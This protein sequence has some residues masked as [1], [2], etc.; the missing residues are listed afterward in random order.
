MVL[1][2]TVLFVVIPISA[3]L[4][5]KTVETT[6]PIPEA[7]G[8]V[9]EV[10]KVPGQ[11]CAVG[12]VGPTFYRQ[13]GRINAAE[14]ARAELGRALQSRVR[15]MMIGTTNVDTSQDINGTKLVE[16]VSSLTDVQLYG[17][18]I[19]K[20]W[21]DKHGIF[22]KGSTFALACMETDLSVK[23]LADKLRQ[24][25]PDSETKEET[26]QMVR[27]RAE[28]AFGAL[29][30]EEAKHQKSDAQLSQPSDEYSEK[31]DAEQ[32]TASDASEQNVI[33]DELDKSENS[34]DQPESNQPPESSQL[35]EDS[36]STEPEVAEPVE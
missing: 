24:A 3:C 26:I 17:A 18:I 25:I 35:G 31:V 12:V 7:P 4:S 34:S 6:S 2:R 15:S 20:Y 32:P 1:E 14:A 27:A 5:C 33:D 29:D 9:E 13:D 28:K 16:V 36:D 23:Q 30:T 10:P 8:W 22:R 21:F 11:I 19:K